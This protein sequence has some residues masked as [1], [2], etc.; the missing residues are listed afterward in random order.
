MLMHISPTL[1]PKDICLPFVPA[2]KFLVFIFH[3]KL[4]WEPTCGSSD[5]I[6]KA[7]IVF[8][9]GHCRVG[10]ELCYFSYTTP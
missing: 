10:I 6:V 5:L 7:V 2:V 8:Y 9:P 4:S 1:Y 3:S